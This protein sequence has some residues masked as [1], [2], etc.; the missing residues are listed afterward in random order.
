MIT[1]NVFALLAASWSG[2]GTCLYK[3]ACTTEAELV[4]DLDIS[5][6]TFAV[7]RFLAYT[8]SRS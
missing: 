7:I 4:M 8:I 2:T 6:Y 3:D 5:R 1:K